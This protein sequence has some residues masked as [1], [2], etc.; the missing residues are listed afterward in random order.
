MAPEFKLKR[1][2]AEEQGGN[3]HVQDEDEDS[4]D[5]IRQKRTAAHEVGKKK[6]EAVGDVLEKAQYQLQ[7]ENLHRSVGCDHSTSIDSKQA[8]NRHKNKRKQ[9]W[10]I[11]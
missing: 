11:G 8:E 10:R 2:E 4:R 9:T 6:E 3:R 1:S 7:S 5:P